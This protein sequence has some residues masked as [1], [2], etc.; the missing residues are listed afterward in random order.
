MASQF[1]T[2]EI[3]ANSTP[4][5]V[6]NAAL[7]ANTTAN[8]VHVSFGGLGLPSAFGS[9]S[10]AE[11]VLV[12]VYV[13]ANGLSNDALV[14]SQTQSVNNGSWSSDF[15]VGKPRTV[16]SNAQVC[17]VA[18][19]PAASI[20]SPSTNGYVNVANTAMIASIYVAALGGGANGTISVESGVL[21]NVA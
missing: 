18:F 16:A 14:F 17:V 11:Q 9:C 10:P 2:T 19:D 8:A 5:L 3:L 6:S 7:I 20:S 1:F 13:G 15:L 12:N 21:L 4:T